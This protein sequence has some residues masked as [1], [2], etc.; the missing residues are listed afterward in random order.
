MTYRTIERIRNEFRVCPSL[1]PLLLVGL[2]VM[3]G[4]C[5]FG[6]RGWLGLVHVSFWVSCLHGGRRWWI[7]WMLF[8][9]G[10]WWGLRT[11]GIPSDSYIHA[12]GRRECRV[13]CRGM[14]VGCPLPGGPFDFAVH[15]MKTAEGWKECSGLVRLRAKGPFTYG[16]NLEV[17]GGMVYPEDG[18]QRRHLRTL[19]IRH[20][21]ECENV[22]MISHASGWRR[23]WGSFLNLRARMSNGLTEGFRSSRLGG[24][25][26]AMS[27]GRRDMFPQAEREL[28]VKSA[29]IHVFAISGLHVNCLMMAAC[30]MLR[31]TWLGSRGARLIALPF[32]ILYVILTGPG[33]SSM[34]AVLMLCGSTLALWMLRRGNDRHVFCLS[35]L[36]LLLFNPLYLLHIGFQFS[37]LIV[38]VLI[39][40]RP[41]QTGMERVVTERWRW[42][43]RT[44]RRLTMVRLVKRLFGVM[45]SCSLAWTGCLSLTLHVNRLMPLGALVVN[46]VVQPVAAMLVGGAVPKIILSY[47]SKKASCLM[48]R[49]LELGMEC[50]VKMAEWGAQDGL[51]REGIIIPFAQA[52]VYVMLIAGLFRRHG[53]RILKSGML[54]G[55][56]SIIVMGVWER[57]EK[58]PGLMLFR[59][60]K[61]SRPC[62]VML[63]HRWEDAFILVPGC[64]AS[65]KMAVQWFKQNGVTTVGSLFIADGVMRGGAQE[66]LRRVN[67][68]S[69]IVGNDWRR[70]W[71]SSRLA[72]SGIHVEYCQMKVNGVHEYCHAGCIWRMS[73]KHGELHFRFEDGKGRL[74]IYYDEKRNGLNLLSSICA[75]YTGNAILKPGMP[76]RNISIKIN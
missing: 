64:N 4:V 56:A 6:W 20:E 73:E 63:N 19:G 36:L 51:C 27:M 11:A 72:A 59:A 75:D 41:L 68:R 54:C 58:M 61:G 23:A 52:C 12:M 40:G 31:L 9:F 44:E 16:D 22:D 35:A 15:G 46:L 74:K 33:P 2:G 69:V 17:T 70:S 29:T 34:R 18:F 30:L 14:V 42:R 43:Q 39:Y 48:G 13:H 10:V 8:V 25:Y 28:F 62:L 37:F 24:M 67:V 53:G 65:A 1:G 76:D 5:G 21:L 60:S 7:S 49:M 57:Y 32:V 66:W 38:G 45:A 55:M 47:I 71:E 26:L 50:A 3:G